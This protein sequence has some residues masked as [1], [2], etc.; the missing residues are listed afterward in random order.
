MPRKLTSKQA[1]AKLKQSINEYNRA[2]RKWKSDV[3]QQNRR[4]NAAINQYNSAVRKHNAA[5]HLNR[6]IIANE[7]RRLSANRTVYTTYSI[8]AVAMQNQYER[9]NQVYSEGTPVTPEQDRILDWVEQE[10]ANSLITENYI[11]N[12]VIPVE[13]TDDVLIGDRL[14]SVSEDLNNRWKGAVYALN[15]KNPDA[16]RHF[17][18]STREIF[19]EFI[20]LKAPD[21]SVLENNPNCELTPD[22]KTPTRRAKIAYMMQ[23]K[24]MDSSVIA[25]ADADIENILS[26]F[27][28]L[29]GGTHGPA[30]K[31]SFE[32]L[33]QVKKRVEQGIIFLCEISA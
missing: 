9:I 8:S 27:S 33:L 23:Q 31:Y 25:F 21:K 29:S 12:D 7:T 20:D 19:T 30:G 10:Q 3:R 22:R 28:T 15:P 17:C 1:I 14:L 16:A 24:R 4:I 26:L 13:D 5:V 32:K 2:V 11:E 18:T 6:Q